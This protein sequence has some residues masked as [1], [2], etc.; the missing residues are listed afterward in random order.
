MVRLCTVPH[1]FFVS[2]PDRKNSTEYGK[3]LGEAGHEIDGI[4]EVGRTS[5]L[6]GG[7]ITGLIGR[8]RKEVEAAGVYG[9]GERNEEQETLVN[10]CKYQDLKVSNT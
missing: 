7:H 2:I 5:M 3:I 8:D 10:A 4:A 9:Y 6:L 1:I